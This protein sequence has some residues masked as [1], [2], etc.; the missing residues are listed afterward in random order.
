MQLLVTQ[1]TIK[2]FRVG[3]MQ[4]LIL[5]TLK[6]RYYKILI[7]RTCIQPVWNILTVNC[8]TN[9]CIRNTCVTWQGIDYKL[10]ED[11]TIVSKHVGVL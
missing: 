9:S 6:S 11:D 1:F 4:V 7:T 2:M 10:S 3:V 5:Q 8:I